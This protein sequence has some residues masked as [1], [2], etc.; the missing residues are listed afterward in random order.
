MDVHRDDSSNRSSNLKLVLFATY[1]FGSPDFDT[2]TD[3]KY[4]EFRL[5][6]VNISYRCRY[7]FLMNIENLPR[8]EMTQLVNSW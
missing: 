2:F 7:T 8:L 6:Q 1:H 4:R 5:Y 3:L